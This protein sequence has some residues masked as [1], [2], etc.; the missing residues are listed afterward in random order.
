MP[1]GGL[2]GKKGKGFRPP[3]VRSVV[4]ESAQKEW[5]NDSIGTQMFIV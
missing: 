5:L 2:G 3:P 1:E 4:R